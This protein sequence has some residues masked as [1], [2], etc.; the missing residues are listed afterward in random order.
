MLKQL[1]ASILY[2]SVPILQQNSHV[3]RDLHGVQNRVLCSTECLSF[4]Y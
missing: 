2:T 1:L 4:E 3:T